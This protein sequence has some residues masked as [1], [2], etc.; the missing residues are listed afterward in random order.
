M[1]VRVHRVLRA[2]VGIPTAVFQFVDEKK[3]N[4]GARASDDGHKLGYAMSNDAY[5]HTLFSTET[6]G[7]SMPTSFTSNSVSTRE[8]P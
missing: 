2:V 3:K 5:I 7:R 4:K 6:Y 8:N 1:L